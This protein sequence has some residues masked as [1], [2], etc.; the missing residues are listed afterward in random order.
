MNRSAGRQRLRRA[1]A[2]GIASLALL[3]GCTTQRAPATNAVQASACVRS[4][5][6]SLDA[7]IT[8]APGLKGSQFSI[9]V[10]DVKSGRTLYER[11]ADQRLI[12]A[13]TLKLLVS[14]AALERLGP[15]YRFTTSV[16]ATGRIENGTLQGNLY[17]RGTGDPTIR[18]AD[19]ADLAARVASLGIRT[20]T[21]NLVFDDTWFDGRLI[22]PGWTTDDESFGFGAPISALT[23]S[24]DND[25]APA[26]VDI[27]V[28]AGATVGTPLL[29]EM[30]PPNGYVKVLNAGL[31]GTSNT[32]TVT[33]EHGL[34]RV[35]VRGMLPV[36]AEP[37]MLSVSVGNPSQYVADL[38][39]RALRAQHV[40]VDGLIIIGEAT[41]DDATLLTEHL[42]MPLSRITVPYL[43]ES[44]NGYAESIT[45]ALGR[46]FGNEGS[47]S[48]GIGSITQFL[49]DNGIDYPMRQVDGSGLSRYNSISVKTFSDLLV[50]AHS[51][52]WFD[53]WYSALPVAGNPDPLIGGTLRNRMRGTPAE[54]NAHAKTG[55]MSGVSGLSGYV[56][57]AEQHL[58]AFSMLTNNALVPV[59]SIEDAIVVELASSHQPSPGCQQPIIAGDR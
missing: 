29:V 16:S 37:Q 58:L 14:T 11:N 32:L 25:Y 4:L 40:Q 41:P 19:Y 10:R 55:S 17:V 38:F 21:G 26:T 48:A 18:P 6:A 3:A 20:I 27:H 33:R 23:A 5:P 39:H 46:A 36:D 42:S 24:P 57:D 50:D 35:V 30:T 47:W 51:K 59:K 54:N 9:V 22:A 44:I 56:T 1:L 43:K 49:R 52:P 31:T 13:S 45:K 8:S 7:I 34:E 15:G 53:I 2:V 12:P 28:K